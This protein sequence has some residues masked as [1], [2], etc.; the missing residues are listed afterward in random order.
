MKTVRYQFLEYG[1]LDGI[2]DL[3]LLVSFK[4]LALLFSVFYVVMKKGLSW[5]LTLDIES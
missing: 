3:I 1:L 2:E 5:D 4:F